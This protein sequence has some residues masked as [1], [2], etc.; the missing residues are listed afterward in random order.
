MYDESRYITRLA[1]LRQEISCGRARL[2]LPL[3]T[4]VSEEAVV[5]HEQKAKGDFAD[6]HRLLG[7][8]VPHYLHI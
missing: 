6:E 3:S 5:E 1:A 7:D 4:L 2:R 8:C